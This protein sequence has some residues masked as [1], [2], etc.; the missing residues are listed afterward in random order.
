MR[1]APP[2][3]VLVGL[4]CP[5]C[6]AVTWSQHPRTICSAC[7]VALEASGP[8]LAGENVIEAKAPP[9]GPSND[10]AADVAT[11]VAAVVRDELRSIVPTVA[12][13][14]A[15]ATSATD[16]GF[17]T[18]D[19]LPPDAPSKRA[20]HDFVKAHPELAATKRGRTWIVDREAWHAARDRTPATKEATAVA[21]V[22]AAKALAAF[23]DR[24]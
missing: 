7:G 13:K 4:L 18:S 5:I 14:V 17:Y 3:F 23:R 11:V 20:F 15:K 9:V 19:A 16:E 6:R 12:A 22:A 2:D 24:S 8:W 1:L 21:E 10:V